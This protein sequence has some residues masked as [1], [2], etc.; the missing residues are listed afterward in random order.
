MC[1]HINREIVVKESICTIE[2][3]V[4]VCTDCGKELTEPKTETS[5]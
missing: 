4:V 2:K 3:V 5:V 1:A